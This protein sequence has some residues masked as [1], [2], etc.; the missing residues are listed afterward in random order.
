MLIGTL[1]VY[2]Y[3]RDVFGSAMSSEEKEVS[4]CQSPAKSGISCSGHLSSLPAR[5][6][7]DVDTQSLHAAVPKA[8]DG[9]S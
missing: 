6:V 3:Q 8:K 7:R 5:S 2:K 4:C 1:F 9:G